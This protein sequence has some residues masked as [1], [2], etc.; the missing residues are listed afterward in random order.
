MLEK[1]SNR[2]SSSSS[3]E[4]SKQINENQT[5]EFP[6]YIKIS[7]MQKDKRIMEINTKLAESSSYT[8]KLKQALD[9]K[10][11][12]HKQL[13]AIIQQLSSELEIKSKEMLSSESTLNAAKEEIKNEALKQKNKKLST[14]IND[15]ISKSSEYQ[16]ELEEAINQ[17]KTIQ[18]SI[19]NKDRE[20]NELKVAVMK[21]EE[22]INALTKN[23]QQINVLNQELNESKALIEKF[24]IQEQKS[25]ND[26][27]DLINENESLNNYIQS[28]LANYQKAKGE[29]E[30]QIVLL[31]N[32]CIDIS[33]QLKQKT[34]DSSM[35]KQKR[36]DVAKEM[37][38]LISYMVNQLSLILLNIDHN[39]SKSSDTLLTSISS[40]GGEWLKDSKYDLVKGNIIRINDKLND[41]NSKLSFQYKILK[42]NI[43]GL[44]IENKELISKIE[45]QRKSE[46]F[47]KNTIEE[48]KKQVNKFEVFNENYNALKNKY[49][50]LSS[51]YEELLT[52]HDKEANDT[53]AFLQRLCSKL[54]KNYN[55]D[56]LLSSLTFENILKVVDALNDDYLQLKM[57]IELNEKDIL[58]LTKANEEI[59]N[60]FKEKEDK[61]NNQLALITSKA[62]KDIQIIKEVSSNQIKQLTKLLEE[63]KSM[64]LKYQSDYDTLLE[65]KSKLDYRLQS[66]Q[67]AQ[68]SMQLILEEENN[69]NS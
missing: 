21:Y 34:S 69:N 14:Q 2:Y 52:K 7:L 30:N 6:D 29:Y 20:I 33:K 59:K 19:V 66:I 65:E 23:N 48:L 1:Y 50:K 55:D 39:R 25:K 26:I 61:L 3:Y 63:S 42:K 51:D 44:T 38:Q 53:T 22:W 37:D 56:Q 11:K 67:S 54:K 40:S 27:V 62:N 60:V 9:Q 68:E 12:D 5:K 4:S 17:N 36:K 28:Y 57:K 64:L 47:D 45:S 16:I 32:Q 46:A 31:E 15:L 24:T 18:I 35:E 41:S 10:E 58:H 43:D 49:V 13:K 8:S